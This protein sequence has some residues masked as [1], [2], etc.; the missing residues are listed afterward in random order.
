MVEPIRLCCGKSHTT[1]LCPDGF[2][3]CQLC[4][5]RVN[6]SGLH[7][8]PDGTKENVCVKCAAKE[9]ELDSQ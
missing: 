7:A 9:L 5:N 8:L 6:T 4:Y 1:A 3:M 2:V